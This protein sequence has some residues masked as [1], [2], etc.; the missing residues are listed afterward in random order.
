MIWDLHMQLL[1]PQVWAEHQV[2]GQ[3]WRTVLSRA[4]G[5]GREVSGQL[6]TPWWWF[7]VG[8]SPRKQ[9]DSAFFFLIQSL[10]LFLF[11]LLSVDLTFLSPVFIL[12]G[13]RNRLPQI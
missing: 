13:C 6:W 12:Y 8:C 5:G 2:S 4:S 1:M 11:H 9:L 3:V 10:S 7:S